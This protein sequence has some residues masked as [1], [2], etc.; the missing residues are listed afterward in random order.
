MMRITKM[1]SVFVAIVILFAFVQG[2]ITNGLQQVA[3]LASEDLART[4]ADRAQANDSKLSTEGDDLPILGSFDKLKELLKNCETNIIYGRGE[5]M[6]TF[7]E[8]ATAS[9]GG[10]NGAASRTDANGAVGGKAVQVPEASQADVNHSSA[11]VQSGEDYSTT[12]TQ[13]QGVDEADIVKTDGTFIYQVNRGRI[14]VMRAYPP[15]NMKIESMLEFSDKN[16][17]PQEM[18]LHGDLLV[19]IGSSMGR[20]I[21]YDSDV[22][23]GDAEAMYY[24]DIISVIE[25]TDIAIYPPGRRIVSTKAIIYNISNKSHIKKLREVELDGS[26]VSSRK[27][28]SAIYFVTNSHIDFYS[29]M[30]ENNED[31]AVP[32]YCD[33]A[34]MSNFKKIGYMDIRYFPGAAQPNYLLVAGVDLEKPYIEAKVSAYLGSGENVYASR[35]NL[36]VAVT[37]YNIRVEDEE[38]ETSTGTGIGEK[39]RAEANIEDGNTVNGNPGIVIV[40]VGRVRPIRYGEQHTKI[41]KFALNGGNIEYVC[42]G[43]VPGRIL[44]QFSMDE[45]DK[46]FRIATT[47]GEIWR[48]DEF[49]SKNNIY[50]LDEKLKEVGKIEG[51]APGEKI[52]SVRFMG[53][54]GYVVTFKTIDPLFVISFKNPEKPEILGALKI[55]G[56]SDYLH[57]YDE[58]HIIGFGKDTVEVKGNAFYLGIKMAIFDITDVNNPKELFT[59]K[60]GDRGTESELLRNHKALLF[61]R[62]KNLLAF[63]VTLMEIKDSSKFDVSGYPKYGQFTFQG[64]YVYN[65]DLEN[66]FTLNARI[67]HLNN[68]ELLKSGNSWYESTK[69]VQRILYIGDVLYTLSDG[70]LKANTLTDFKELNSLQIN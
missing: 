40:P 29:I 4:E 27:T 26:Y 25:D 50:V 18:Y 46:Y 8:A 22:P 45:Y 47:T 44:N 43:S 49:T 58:N 13:V 16:F 55:P 57:P 42:K 66:G 9:V 41:Y 70:M 38:A 61:S 11:D 32:Y 35:D 20:R 7:S 60:I 51:I 62:E 23:W 10:A 48:N 36:Y 54:R 52:Y 65:I 53:E 59:E 14:A 30:E 63:P 2:P 17:S 68:D 15:E 24:S 5:I 39:V 12:N 1:L 3:L 31:L 21:T 34:S 69:N 67:T 6:V 33:S 19:V 64:A 37:D 56:Y 28:G